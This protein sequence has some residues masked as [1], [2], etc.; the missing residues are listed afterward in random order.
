MSGRA[1]ILCFFHNFC[2]NI[3]NVG[4]LKR[5]HQRKP[6]KCYE[7]SEAYGVGREV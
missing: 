6:M 3:R 5:L 4:S 2:Y 7:G 1:E